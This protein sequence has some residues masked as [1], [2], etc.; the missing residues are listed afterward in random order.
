MLF[1][2]IR[3]RLWQYWQGEA[4]EATG[5]VGVEELLTTKAGDNQ[6]QA[7]VLLTTHDI[8]TQHQVLD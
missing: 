2:P 7:V 3:L 6:P 8:L 4:V 5:D 1:I